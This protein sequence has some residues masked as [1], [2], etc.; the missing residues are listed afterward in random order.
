MTNTAEATVEATWHVIISLRLGICHSR[1]LA[2]LGK[3]GNLGED[4]CMELPRSFGV[5]VR[6]AST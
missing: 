6:A 4:H 5:V 1:S 2:E 3:L